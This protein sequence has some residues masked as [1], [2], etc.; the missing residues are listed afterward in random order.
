MWNG[1]T[2]LTRA[3]DGAL[4]VEVGGGGGCFLKPFLILT[5]GVPMNMHGLCSFGKS[6]KK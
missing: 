6:E 3:M 5:Q 1:W 2:P 4:V